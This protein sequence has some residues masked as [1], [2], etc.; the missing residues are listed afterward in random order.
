MTNTVT[1]ML[2]KQ[3]VS[4]SHP[5]DGVHVVLNVA[6]T[7]NVPD[8]DFFAS[9]HAFEAYK[10]PP[11]LQ[12]TTSICSGAPE[13]G[14]AVSAESVEKFAKSVEH[15][16]QKI[17]ENSDFEYDDCQNAVVRTLNDEAEE[18]SDALQEAFE[19]FIESCDYID[20]DVEVVDCEDFWTLETLK[21]LYE[22]GMSDEQFAEAILKAQTE[23]EKEDFRILGDPSCL[24]DEALGQ[25]QSA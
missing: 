24:M 16:C 9:E 23:A 7:N 14:F 8:V 1:N 13:F 21:A 25:L 18:A 6:K 22:P 19:A 2:P 10:A 5:L 15:L 20:T 3:V 4:A 12:L 17:N 11:T